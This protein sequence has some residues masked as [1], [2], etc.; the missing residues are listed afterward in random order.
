[1][2]RLG[3][4]FW[5]IKL[6]QLALA[7]QTPAVR[8]TGRPHTENGPP[9]GRPFLK[10]APKMEGNIST[11]LIVDNDS[12]FRKLLRTLLEQGGDFAF[13]VEAESGVEAMEKAK[14]LLPN[15]V[16]LDFAMPGT[17]GLQLAHNLLAIMPELPIFMLTAEL[18]FHIEK[19][20]L[21]SGIIA[22]FSKFDDLQTLL[23]NARAVCGIK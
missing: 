17:N 14:Q 20:A 10:D 16:I 11:V 4:R 12:A 1:L 7:H 5:A 6:Q 13:C 21:A 3:S 15:L 18:S 22:V 9:L 19:E 2:V 23:A 8:P